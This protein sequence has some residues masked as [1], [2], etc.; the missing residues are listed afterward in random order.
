M[1]DTIWL[2]L[3]TPHKDA[4]RQ[5]KGGRLKGMTDI[6]PQWRLFAMTELFGP[7]GVGWWYVI[8]SVDYKDG[9]EGQVALFVRISLFVVI[10]GKESHAIPGVGGSKLIEK[11]SSG[12]HFNDEA[13]KMATTDALSV[14]MKQLGLAADVY[15][16]NMDGSKY[17]KPE[18]VAALSEAISTEQEQ[19]ILQLIKDTGANLD[20]FLS[21]FKIGMVE[22]LVVS[23]YKKA[24]DL[25]LKK[26]AKSQ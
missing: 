11:E 23:Q 21:Y 22:Q 3:K 13:L 9:P 1:N 5:I 25:L 24:K 7:I 17:Q 14:A 16:N 8:E 10:E 19:E 2:K 4:L 18:D 26:K 6:N 15:M 12:L 20:E